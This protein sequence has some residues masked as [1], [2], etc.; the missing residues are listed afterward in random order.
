MQ[1]AGGGS[2]RPTWTHCPGYGAAATEHVPHPVPPKVGHA[3]RWLRHDGPGPIL[4]PTPPHGRGRDQPLA[5]VAA[6]PAGPRARR[7][8]L[9]RNEGKED[10]TRAHWPG[11]QGAGRAPGVNP[12]CCGCSAKQRRAGQR[13]G[14][15]GD[16]LLKG[17][18][19][20]QE[21]TGWGKGCWPG[22]QLTGLKMKGARA[23]KAARVALAAM[24]C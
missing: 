4:P 13:G 16:L 9:G 19:R 18:C 1:G 22:T 17:Q 14:G 10:P 2:E 3:S 24:V 5:D 20:E 15:L 7:T 11:R 23:I 12:P 6:R 21:R 8:T